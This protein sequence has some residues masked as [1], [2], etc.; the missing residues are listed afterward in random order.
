MLVRVEVKEWRAKIVGCF[1]IEEG[2]L[3]KDAS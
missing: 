3:F 2:A 1:A